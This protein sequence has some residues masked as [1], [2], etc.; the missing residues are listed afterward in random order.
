MNGLIC[1][2]PSSVAT[3][4]F[5][6]VSPRRS[7]TARV[8]ARVLPPLMNKAGVAISAYSLSVVG[9]SIMMPNSSATLG[10]VAAMAALKRSGESRQRQRP[11]Q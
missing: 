10:M 2:A 11:S 3:L 1:P 5:G 7:T 9:A 4:A 6:K 8:G